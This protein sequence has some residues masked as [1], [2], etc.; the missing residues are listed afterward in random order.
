MLFGRSEKKNI[1]WDKIGRRKNTKH[2]NLYVFKRDTLVTLC[3]HTFALWK[4]R[5]VKYL[6]T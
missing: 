2:R 6:N 4:M 1:K 3:T 5:T